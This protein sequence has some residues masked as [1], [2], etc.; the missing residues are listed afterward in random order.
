[1]LAVTLRLIRYDGRGCG[2]SD[3]EATDF[4]LDRCVEDLEAVVDSC[5]LDRFVLFGATIGGMTALAYAA[6]H[7]ERVTHLIIIGGLAV[8][9]MKRKPTPEAIEETALELK[10]IELG[11]GN[12]NPAFRQFFTTLFIPE[13]TLEQAAR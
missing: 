4:S 7:P 8:G 11:W 13:S 9:R 1:M 2:L 12:D 6:R 10:A 3:W 5:K